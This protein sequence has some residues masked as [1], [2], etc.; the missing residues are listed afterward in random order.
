MNSKSMAGW[1]GFAGILMLI[2]GG[3]DFFQGLIALLEDDYYV[4]TG[5]GF[6]VLDLTGW[7][8]T[9]LIWGALLVLAAFGLLA[10]QTWARW[11]AIVV[12]GLNFCPARLPREHPEHALV[13]DGDSPEYRRALCAD[14]TLE[15][16]PGRATPLANGALLDRGRRARKRRARRL[17]VRSR[18]TRA[19][20]DAGVRVGGVCDDLAASVVK[21][22]CSALVNRADRECKR[23]ADRRDKPGELA[24]VM[25]GL[26][27]HRVGEHGQ[28][29]ATGECEH[30]GDGSRRCGIEYDV[31]GKGRNAEADGYEYPEADD[32]GR[33]PP[34]PS[35]GRRRCDRLGDVRDEDSDQQRDADGASLEH[36][37]AEDERLGDT[38]EDDPER[39]RS[40]RFLPHACHPRSC[41]CSSAPASA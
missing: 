24:A 25:Q 35:E 17:P 11:F 26:R 38:V 37:E 8:W 5:S 1:I 14:R 40:V 33:F 16:E 18:V 28:D 13:T 2:V 31:A 15:R 30:D 39:H 27:H 41:S 22:R 4:P 9:M 10:G 19:S 12:V 32:P 36:G 23:E 29:S 21:P 7:G 34:C 20:L 6:L 3:I